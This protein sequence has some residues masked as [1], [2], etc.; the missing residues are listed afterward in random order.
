[1]PEDDQL[2]FFPLF[3]KSAAIDWYDGLSAIQKRSTESLLK[4]FEQYF[5]PSPINGPSPEYRISLQQKPEAWRESAGLCRGD[6]E[7]S[8]P[9]TGGGRRLAEMYGTQRSTAADKGLCPSARE[10]HPHGRR[11]LNTRQ[12]GRGGGNRDNRSQRRHGCGDG[13]DS[14]KSSGGAHADQP[15]GPDVVKRHRSVAES[16][17][18]Q[19][20]TQK[21]EVHCD[22]GH[23]AG[24]Q[25]QRPTEVRVNDAAEVTMVSV[26]R[27][28]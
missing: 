11:H 6:A 5:C 16:G 17:S 2:A 26:Q 19:A 8:T 22:E 24:R 21:D 25:R 27:P 3:L 4:E 14:A 7:V 18:R 13:R 15:L 28:I 10:R 1:M 23:L 12:G 9:H 20:R